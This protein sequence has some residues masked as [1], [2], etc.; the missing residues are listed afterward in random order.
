ML[1]ESY[2]DYGIDLSDN[3]TGQHYTVCPQCSFKRKKQNIKCLGINADSGL[4]HCFHCGWSGVLRNKKEDDYMPIKK[5]TKP[6]EIDTGELPIRVVDWFAKR[7]ITIETLKHFDIKYTKTYFSQ[8]NEEETAT[9]FPYKRDGDIVNYKYRSGKKHF[10]QSKNA[11]KIFFNIDCISDKLDYL[12]ICEGEIDAMSFYQ[13]GYKFVLSIPDGAPSPLAKNFDGKFDYLVNCEDDL[14]DIENIIIAVDND[15]P[16]RVLERELSR[17]LG[18]ERCYKVVY[19]DGCKDANEVLIK[20]S[21]DGIDELIGSASEYPIQGVFSVEDVWNDVLDY[22]RNGVSTGVTTGFQTLDEHYTIRP[23]EMTIWTGYTGH[24]KSE[25]LDQLLINLASLHDWNFGICSLENLPIKNHIGKLIAKYNGVAFHGLNS[26]QEKEVIDGMNFL[27]KRFRFICPEEVS[28]DNLFEIAKQLIARYGIKGFVIDPW[29]ELDHKKPMMQS[30]TE[31][32]SEALSRIRRF[33]RDNEIHIWVVAHPTKPIK[34]RDLDAPKLYDISGSANWANK[35]DC[36]ISIFRNTR[37]NNVQ[38]N[39]TKI[40][41]K[42]IGK[43][44]TVDFDY[45]IPSG[46]YSESIIQNADYN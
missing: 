3:A 42:E 39:I 40:R 19:P 22:W 6:K 38:V 43:P 10:K 44:G 23:G 13:A 46:R 20:Y 29:N 41:F 14:R 8:S 15:E 32:I 24:G 31:Y 1:R 28:L 18:R 11:E 37:D 17:R 33:A 30:E 26:M 25:F 36:G 27:K 4:W 45:D 21:T 9:V 16:G 35:A 12:I 7:K 5:Y 34:G 2:K